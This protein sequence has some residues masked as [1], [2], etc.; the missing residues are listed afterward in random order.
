[1][2]NSSTSLGI[3]PLGM[4]IEFV[5]FCLCLGL[6]ENDDVFMNTLGAVIGTVSYVL[7]GKL[8]NDNYRQ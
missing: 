3:I 5:Q 2:Y 7:Q 6:C 4:T 8:N 1:V